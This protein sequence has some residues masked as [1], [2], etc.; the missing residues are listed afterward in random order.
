MNIKRGKTYHSDP[1][2]PRIERKCDMGFL[3]ALEFLTIIPS[4]LRRKATPREVGRSLVYFP[5]IGLGIG[6]LLYGL[7]Q[8]FQLAL[9]L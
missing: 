7:D 4:P 8:L 3:R 2:E 1:G 5:V 6:G 9:H